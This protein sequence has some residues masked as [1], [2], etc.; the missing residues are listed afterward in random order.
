M[1]DKMHERQDLTQGSMLRHVILFSLPMLLGNLLQALYNTVDSIWVGKFLGP[2]ALGA[3][4]VSGPVIMVLVSSLMGLTMATTVL[5]AQYWG[6]KRPEMVKRTINNTFFLLSIAAIVLTILGIR[7]N[8][9]ILRL[10]NTPEE[11]LPMASSYLNIYL[12]GLIFMFGY[13]V[14]SAILRGLGDSNTP[15]KFLA[16]A[17]VINIILDPLLILG[18]GPFPRMEVAGAALATTLAQGISFIAAAGYLNKQGHL[19]SVNLKEFKFDKDLTLKT[20]QIGIPSGI[21]MSV[22]SIGALVVNSIINTFGTDTVASFG[23]ASRL[24]QFAMM[25]SQSISMATSAIAGQNIGAGKEENVK[26]TVKWATFLAVG[27]ASMMTLIAQLTPATLLSLFT[28]DEMLLELGKG[29]LRILS[30]GYVPMALMFITNGL[31]RG[32]GDTFPTMLFSIA[33]L[34]V[35]RVPLAKALSSIPSLGANGIWI[36]MVTSSVL[37]MLMSRIYYASGRWKEKQILA[38]IP[39]AE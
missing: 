23:M 11:I 33:S 27:I 36:A 32:A 7:F 31:L 20:I 26:D 17:T 28:S 30:L 24:D 34:W 6:A 39:T 13:N 19:L 16:L 35:I 29:H 18:I 10:I 3:V 25:P 15:L 14:T 5:V 38:E 4:S 1:G 37:S 21:Q 2:E 8:E 12:L 22:V 9:A